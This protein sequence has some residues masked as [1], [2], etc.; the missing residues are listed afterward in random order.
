MVVP[1]SF[2]VKA[3]AEAEGLDAH[4]HRRRLRLARAGLLDVPGH[5]PRQAAPSASGPPRPATATSRAARAGA[6]AP[7]SCPPPSPPPPPSPAPSPPPPTWPETRPTDRPR[8]T[9]HG[10]RHRRHRHRRARSTAPTS[11]PTRSSP[12]TGSS[13]SS[14]PASAPG[15]FSEWR[16]DRDF[17]LNHEHYTGATILVAGPNFGTGS[18]REHAVWAI[19]DY[20]FQA[21]ISP[22]FAD[23]FR[24]NCTKNGLVPVQVDAEVGEQLLRAVEADPTLEITID[25]AARTAVGAGH[26]PRGRRSRSTT[27]PATA[28]SQ[29]LD[30]I[31][32][33]LAHDDAI[34]AYE[35]PP[36]GLEAA[37][38]GLTLDLGPTDRP[39]RLSPSDE[40]PVAVAAGGL[41]PVHGLVATISRRSP[42]TAVPVGP[43]RRR[44]RCRPCTV[45]SPGR[46]SGRSIDSMIRSARVASDVGVGHALAQDRRTRRRRPGPPGRPRG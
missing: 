23:I 15:L 30:D 17:V 45:A 40:D 35:A 16:D 14:A 44:S 27:P 24:N 43:R 29:G 12:A 6:G 33:T 22:R 8:R 3:Q 1:G 37:R 42:S 31:G 21:V 28:S 9:P 38:H 11:T 36:P 7:T 41:G 18:S 2:R 4:L 46:R 10:T 25:V 19:M 34:A 20:G 13:G 39:P 32:I 5:E 26:R